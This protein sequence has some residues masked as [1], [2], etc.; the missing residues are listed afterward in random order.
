MENWI[1][2]DW[3]DK[4]PVY[5]TKIEMEKVR[6]CIMLINK[7]AEI[8]YFKKDSED[9]NDYELLNRIAF[10]DRLANKFRW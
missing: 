1:E 7:D 10:Y 9:E 2:P 3:T 4:K 6:C 5:L 8:E